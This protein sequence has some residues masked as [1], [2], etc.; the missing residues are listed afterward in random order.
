MDNNF[1][2]PDLYALPSPTLCP[3]L[4]NHVLPAMRD[5]QAIIPPGCNV[6]FDTL[7]LSR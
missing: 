7:L 5:H 6:H 3:P 4:V 2:K 1:C